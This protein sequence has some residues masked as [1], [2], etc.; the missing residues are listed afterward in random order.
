MSEPAPDTSRP[1]RRADAAT[2]I[3]NRY[4]LPCEASSLRTMACKG[5]GP[6]FRKG[7]R[8]PLYD[9]ADLDA[10]A[11]SKLS[12]KVKS[13]SELSALRAVSSASGRVSP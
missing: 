10:W 2:Y 8:F 5:T 9:I 11:E 4:N 12:P 13:T 3:R 7:S 1:L 6:A